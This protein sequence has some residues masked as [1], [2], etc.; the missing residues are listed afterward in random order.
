M[1]EDVRSNLTNALFG[2]LIGTD[3]GENADITR[4]KERIDNI[5]HTYNLSTDASF[6]EGLAKLD[7]GD[8]NEKFELSALPKDL[9]NASVL[10][11]TTITDIAIRQDIDLMIS[12]IPEW[13][14]ALIVTRDS[15]CEADVATGKIARD[16]RF[17]ETENDDETNLDIMSKIEEVEERLDLHSIIKNDITF[18]TLE[19]GEGYIYV[20]PYSSVF[21]DLYR[22]KVSTDDKKKRSSVSGM[23]DSSPAI[24]GYG[25][26]YGESMKCEVSLSDAL[27]VMESA[28][29]TKKRRVNNCLFTEAEVMEV[30]PNYFAEPIKEAGQPSNAQSI[31]IEEAAKFDAATKFIA[32]NIRFVKEDVALPVF[33][34]SIEEM[35]ESYRVKYQ[36]SN[37]DDVKKV[38]T[39]FE[40]VMEAT[41]D[42]YSD[43]IDKEFQN[44]KGVYIKVINGTKMIPIR[45]DR[46]IIGYYYISDLTRPEENGERKN[47][48]ASSY[49]LRTPS[50][51]Y[52]TFSPDR[53]FCEKLANKIING[54]NLKFM[55]DNTALH[56]QIVSILE[57][58]KFNESL[59]R[60][61][62]I[63]AEHVVQCS[64]NRDSNGKG[65]SMLEPGLVSARMYMFLKLYSIL[66]QI[67]NSEVRVINLNLSGIDK[68]YKRFVQDTVR[69]FSA[70]RVTANDIFN[71]RSSMT[72]VSGGSELVMPVGT[73]NK[74]PLTFETIPAS[75][76]PINNDLLENQKNEAINANPVPSAMVQ[77]AMSELDFAKEVELANTRFKSF[78]SST[79]ID[80]NR[81]ISKLYRKVL[82][83]ETDIDPDILRNLK[84]IFRAPTAQELNITNDMLNNF[85]S[86][87]DVMM[88]TFFSK[89]ELD[90]G[91][92]EGENNSIIAREYRKLLIREFI[93]QVDIDRFQ[94]LADMARDRANRKMLDKRNQSENLT[95]EE[96]DKEES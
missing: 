78:I 81:D 75:S 8:S 31:N 92:E 72:K 82:R 52:D 19:Y 34:H 74:P 23:F 18:D 66:Y 76:V 86:I 96:L 89:K 63:P 29:D 71:Y 57:S 79:K 83:W 64:I 10:P 5:L 40:S 80:L 36:E 95:D 51:G 48:G 7:F 90:G 65:H 17:D 44:I 77:G 3:N 46:N 1:A 50:V 47:N 14:S 68:D 30:H 58:H 88:P 43:S 11:V 39:F 12:Q 16:I 28:E 9:E 35:E 13:Y 61:I 53:M 41:V 62:F 87:C 21:Q 24:S 42:P 4:V 38:Q 91:K 26:G 25:Y 70:R 22:Y 54:F 33:E 85:N 32:D 59:M 56:Q 27:V 60:F 67:N 37:H 45:V 73:A 49:T 93:P 2:D 6:V 94:E 15:I 69:K 20:R 55:R 84:F